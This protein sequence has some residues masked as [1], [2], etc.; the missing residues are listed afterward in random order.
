MTPSCSVR[1]IAIVCVTAALTHAAHAQQPYPSKS[2]RLIVPFPP[3]GSVDPIARMIAS[4][5]SESLGQQV[6]V[7][8]RPGANGAIGTE[9]LAKAPPDGYTLI[10]LG[11]GTHV[12]NALLVRNLPYDSM[13]DFAPVATIQRSDYVL[14]VH[15]SL[16][17]SNVKELV[18]LAKSRPGQIAYASSGNGNMNHLAAELFNMITGSK[19]YHIPYKGAG[20]ALIDLMSGQVQMHFSVTISALPHVK[21][22]RL[23]PVAFGGEKRFPALPQVE[24]FAEAGLAGLSLRPWQGVLAPARTPK[25]VVDRLS[26]EIARIIALPDITE[27]LASLGMTPLITTPEQF[28]ALMASEYAKSAEVIKAA[29]IKLD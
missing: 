26:T 22:G 8:N 5:L 12:I 7:D 14:V 15:P 20:P 6:F 25:P 21:T 2:I 18:A 10:H 11:P 28:A 1:R 27:R 23:K 29:N 13:K 19:T 24:T 3:G 16:P 4:K 9:L 17:V